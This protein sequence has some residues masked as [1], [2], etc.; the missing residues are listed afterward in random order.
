M[1]LNLQPT[2]IFINDSQ[3][4]L[5]QIYGIPWDT[6]STPTETIL[7]LLDQPFLRK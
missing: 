1:F 5:M 7:N 2:K 4:N 6:Y 3:I